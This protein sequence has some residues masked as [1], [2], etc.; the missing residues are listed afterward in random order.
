M[1][2]SAQ[3]DAFAK[4]SFL[5][6]GNAAFLEQLYAQY[7][8]NPAS[9]DT[10]WHE[11]FA[12]LGDDPVLYQHIGGVGQIVGDDGSVLDDCAHG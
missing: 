8:D 9:V 10:E 2:K 1:T 7:Q 4:T 3:N 12:D 6:G 5:Y 11:F